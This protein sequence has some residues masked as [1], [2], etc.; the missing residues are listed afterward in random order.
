MPESSG[1]L[2][3]GANEFQCIEHVH[4]VEYPLSLTIV[5]CVFNVWQRFGEPARLR[6]ANCLSVCASGGMSCLHCLGNK[7][8]HDNRV[9][10]TI[11]VYK[12]TSI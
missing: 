5:K 3:C 11:N 10:Y 4:M 6:M 2:S 8:K 12:D 7:S 1:L 9:S